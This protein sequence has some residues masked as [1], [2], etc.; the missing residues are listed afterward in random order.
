MRVLVFGDSITQGFWAVEHGWVDRVR[1]HYDSVQLDD[2]NGKDE[3]TIFNLGIS[4]DTSADLVSRIGQEVAA[5]TIPGQKPIVIVQIGVNDSYTDRRGKKIEV[6][7]YKDNLRLIVQLLQGLTSKTIF[8][9]LSANKD[10]MTSPAAWRHDLYYNGNE[11]KKYEEAMKNVAAEM[12]IPF[13]PV[14]NSFKEH[15]DAGE[16]LLP[17]GLHPNDVGHELIYQI[18]MP[19]LQELLV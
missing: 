1:T 15:I 4:G 8:V 6:N 10:D 19:R 3:P 16:D 17:D 18:V 2:L 14:F 13:I 12:D 5:R 11:I 9:G 7:I